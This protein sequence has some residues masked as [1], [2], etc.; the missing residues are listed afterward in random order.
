[1]IV[2]DS[3]LQKVDKPGLWFLKSSRPSS[4]ISDLVYELGVNGSTHL[5]VRTQFK[6]EVHNNV[7][8]KIIKSIIDGASDVNERKWLEQEMLDYK[9]HGFSSNLQV[10]NDYIE[11]GFFWNDTVIMIDEIPLFCLNYRNAIIILEDI[12]DLGYDDE[13]D[14]LKALQLYHEDA[15]RIKSTVIVLVQE[16]NYGSATEFIEKHLFE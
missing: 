12:N 7:I 10:M 13:T 14:F 1:M 16:K 8:S 6:K 2:S 3:M 11:E 5:Y 4:D 9:E 15:I